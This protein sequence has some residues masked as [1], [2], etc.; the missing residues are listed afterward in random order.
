MSYSRLGVYGGTFNPL[1]IGHLIIAQE[2][3]EQCGLDRVLLMPSARPPHKAP[4]GIAPP[5]D[6]YR[7]ALAA[8]THDN[9]FEVSDLEI[10]RPGL[11][12]TIETLEALRETYG[13]GCRLFFAI[14]MDS[15]VDMGTWRDP[16]RVFGLATIVAVAR[17]GVDIRL[18]PTP[19]RDRVITLQTPEVDI[20][21][22]DIRRRVAEGRSIRY[23]VPESVERYIREHRLYTA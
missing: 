22:T 19:W 21:S 4:D 7:M 15:L 5:E 2:F 12:Y 1:H 3:Y 9:R 18:A 8:V 14:G 20:S 11:S 23:L 10:R 16:D 17:P 13:P 6:R